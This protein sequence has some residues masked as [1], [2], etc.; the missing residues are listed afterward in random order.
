MLR[1]GLERRDWEAVG[2]AATLSACLHQSILSSPL[3]E[4]VLALVEEVRALGV[5]RAHS[6][7]LL[8]LLLDPCCADPFAVAAFVSRNVPN[9]VA[10]TSYRLVNGG[11]RCATDVNYQ[12]HSNE[13]VTK[14]ALAKQ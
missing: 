13:T 4:P 10:V 11:P 5:C 7:T 3:L 8:G 1:Q 12:N 2:E 9:T 6:G 14:P